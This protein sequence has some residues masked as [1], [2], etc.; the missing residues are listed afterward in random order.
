M[1]RPDALVPF[2]KRIIALIRGTILSVSA[3][4]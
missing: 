1:E 3:G 4:Q 2:G